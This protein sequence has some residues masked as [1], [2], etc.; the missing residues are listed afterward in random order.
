MI[1][2]KDIS[3]VVQG[4]ISKEETPKCLKSVRKFLPDAEIIL[5][6]WEGSDVS[7][8]DGLYDILLLNK[9]PGCGYYYKNETG[10]KSNNL[11]RQL[12]STQEGLKKATKTYALKIRSDI[13]LTSN[14]F[15][16][17][18]DYYPKRDEKYSLFKHKIVAS[19]I[20]SRFVLNDYL[21]INQIAEIKLAFHISDWW[22][23]GLK[24]DLVQYFDVPLVEE[25]DFSN[26]YKKEENKNKFNPY[27]YF[28]ESYVQFSPEQ[29]F[30]IK[31]FEQKFNDIQLEHAGDIS[32][33]KFELSRKYVIN[34]FIFTEYCESGVYFKK[35]LITRYP[36][37]S[38]AYFD[39]YNKFLQ[40]YEYK[41]Y[42]DA[43]YQIDELAKFIYMSNNEFENDVRTL[44]IHLHRVHSKQYLNSIL[45][46]IFYTFIYSLRLFRYLPQITTLSIKNLCNNF[47]GK[48]G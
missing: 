4:A 10:T 20:G 34:N 35:Y 11:N 31:C 37:L 28:D 30:A 17:Y 32:D 16:K 18:F 26:Y 12:V 40:Q 22:F 1:E 2:S 36:K 41:K 15:L 33:E 9:D 43:E 25:P 48:N 3:V 5:S 38:S 7:A 44:L 6:T 21:N 29:Y 45:K 24:E 19:S 47:R 27:I 8:L 14:K 42:C 13:I 46:E 39:M 23:F